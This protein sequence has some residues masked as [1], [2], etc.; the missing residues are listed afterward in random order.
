MSD[1][2]RPQHNRPARRGNS[3]S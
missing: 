1:R 3:P 2:N